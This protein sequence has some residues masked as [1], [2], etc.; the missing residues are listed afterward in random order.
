MIRARSFFRYPAL[1]QAHNPVMRLET[2]IGWRDMQ[3]PGDV[4][5]VQRPESGASVL[6]AAAAALDPYSTGIVQQM[7]EERQFFPSLDRQMEGRE[8]RTTF[9]LLHVPEHYRL[10]TAQ[11][12]SSSRLPMSDGQ[13]DFVFSDE[14]SGVLAVKYGSEILYA[15]LY[16]RA[17][18]AVNFLARIHHITPELERLATV[19]QEVEFQPS[20]RI[21]VRPGW[22]NSRRRCRRA[23]LPGQ[24][25]LDPCRRNPPDRPAAENGRNGAGESARRTG[26]LLQ[27]SLRPVSLCHECVVPGA[28]LHD[29]EEYCL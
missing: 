13:P 14:E 16:W 12:A 4:T 23:Q 26:G 1:N 11:P 22:T 18:H 7:F 17:P 19:R 28:L 27:A 6:Q 5:Y 20:G 24:R 25:P 10:L 8:F 3:F 21:F 2:V 15:S 29:A 9:G